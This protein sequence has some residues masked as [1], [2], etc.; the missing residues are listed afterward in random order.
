MEQ[1]GR[2]VYPNDK[3]ELF[4]AEGDYGFDS[5]IGKWECRPPGCHAGTLSQ[6]EVVVNPDG[7][8]TVS[9]SIV[10]E[11]VDEKGEK[12]TWH[13]WLQEGVWKWN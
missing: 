4:L 11:D 1:K 12:K 13:G 6:H 9:P 8:I 2:R 7:T 10:L 3:G 5:R